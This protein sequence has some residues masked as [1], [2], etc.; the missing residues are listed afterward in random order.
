[1]FRG[2]RWLIGIMGK[3]FSAGLGY[4][5]QFKG[6]LPKSILGFY[7]V[8]TFFI[9]LATQ[10]FSVALTEFGKSIFSAEMVIR[11]NVM[12]AVAGDPTYGIFNL[13]EIVFSIMMLWYIL[14]FMFW[15]AKS[16]Q[17]ESIPKIPT[18]ALL[19]LI[20]A[21]IEFAVASMINK[22][23]DFIP[24]VDGIGYLLFNIQPVLMNVHIFG[25]PIFNAALKT[26][27]ES[28]IEGI[29]SSLQTSQ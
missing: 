28:A 10:G 1:M 26:L 23:F 2:L 5:L 13:I 25:H 4:I 6:L 18:M 27:E 14:K 12:L 7:V 9:N 15:I 24:I 19:C 20:L 8:I 3:P 21:I 16:F 22:N 17:G 29:N 11:E